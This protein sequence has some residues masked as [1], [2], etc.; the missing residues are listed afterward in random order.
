MEA[1]LIQRL[2]DWNKVPDKIQSR[3]YSCYVISELNLI[4]VPI[5]TWWLDSGA[6]THVLTC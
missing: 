2:P 4:D 6:T 1:T 3:Q 5:H